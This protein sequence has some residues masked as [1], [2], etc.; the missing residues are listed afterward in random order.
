[1]EG[2]KSRVLWRADDGR[3]MGFQHWA[4]DDDVI[5]VSR[6]EPDG[7]SELLVIS[8]VEGRIRTSFPYASGSLVGAS[9][10]PDGR[11]V[12]YEKPD[13]ATGLADIY[14]RDVDAGSEAPLISDASSDQSPVWTPDGR[15]VIFVSYRSGTSA[16]WMQTMENGKPIGQP[17]RIEPNLGWAYPMGGLTRTGALFFRRQIGTRDVYAVDIDPV[18]LSLSG[19]P[20][21]VSAEGVGANGSSAWSPDSTRLAFFRRRGDQQ[22][23]LIVKSVDDGKEREFRKPYLEGIARP[24]WEADG[25]SLLFE[26]VAQRPSRPVPARSRERA[27][28]AR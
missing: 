28:S 24:R 9:L 17:T 6:D 2:G 12:V 15:H 14:I 4:G 5:L 10:S 8:T 27:M 13:P 1:M 7:A 25:R 22:R 26:G 11:S 3:D 20:K 23:S 19:E 18:T 21:R 16:L